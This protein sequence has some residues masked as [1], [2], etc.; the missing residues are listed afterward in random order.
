[1]RASKHFQKQDSTER[2]PA[3]L[4]RTLN[5]ARHYDESN[6]RSGACDTLNYSF[7]N[8][9]S[10]MLQSFGHVEQQQTA[11]RLSQLEVLVEVVFG[12]Q[13]KMLAMQMAT[14]EKQQTLM[15]KLESVDRKLD[16]LLSD[17]P[18]K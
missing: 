5:G 7:Q 6:V 1:M 10:A 9:N 14:H 17:Q 11:A 16:L 13:Q 3:A 4:S 8:E 15:T 12:L 2:Q 18:D